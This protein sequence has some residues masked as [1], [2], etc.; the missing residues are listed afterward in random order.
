MYFLYSSTSTKYNH[1]VI[2]MFFLPLD[3]VVIWRL[4]PFLYDKD[5]YWP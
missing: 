5:K 2:Y 3:L 1:T 4:F